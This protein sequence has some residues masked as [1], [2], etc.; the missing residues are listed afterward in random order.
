MALVKFTGDSIAK[1][2]LC[3]VRNDVL[4][5]VGPLQL[6]AGQP[7]GCEVAIHDMRAVFD[8]PD[9]EAVLQAGTTNAFNCLNQQVALRNI[10]AICPSFARILI[11][12]YRDESKLY[13]DGSYILSKEGTT[14][15]DPLAMPMYALGVVPH[16]PAIG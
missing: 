16:H 13:I 15:G 6:C 9:A 3:M 2:V 12:T 4:Q 10:S 5:V 1:A 7:S 14:E 8:S 11:N